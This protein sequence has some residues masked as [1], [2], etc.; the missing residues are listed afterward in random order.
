MPLDNSRQ[1]LAHLVTVQLSLNNKTAYNTQR[2]IWKRLLRI[3][4]LSLL[5]RKPEAVGGLH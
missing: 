1:R 5:W 3:P 4:N 2:L